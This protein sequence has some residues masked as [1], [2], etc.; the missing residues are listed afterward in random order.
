MRLEPSPEPAWIVC[1]AGTGGTSATL[2]RYVRYQHH[3]TR[4]AVVDPE[5]SVFY[6]SY[7]S[8]SRDCVCEGGSGVEGIGRPRVEPSF[9]A[10]VIDRM[11]RVPNVAS[12]AAVHFLEEVMGRRCGGSTGTN[13]F[14]VFT[15]MNE[16]RAA[17]QSGSVVTLICDDGNRYENTYFNRDW[18]REHGHDIEPWLATYRRFFES[19]QWVLPS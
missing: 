9:I 12:Y 7:Y 10:G 3:S 13:L 17:G 1:G 18:L 11:I 2:G 16:M 14:G 19:G 8:G 6:D 4:I 5:N 15:L